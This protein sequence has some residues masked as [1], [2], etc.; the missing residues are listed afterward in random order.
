VTR[1]SLGLRIVKYGV[2]FTFVWMLWRLNDHAAPG[3][4]VAPAGICFTGHVCERAIYSTPDLQ[5]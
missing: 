4:D 3:P 1:P 2:I 5:P